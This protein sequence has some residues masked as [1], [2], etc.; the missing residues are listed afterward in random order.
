[1]CDRFIDHMETG[2]RSG[3]LVNDLQCIQNLR[4]FMKPIMVVTRIVGTRSGYGHIVEIFVV[5]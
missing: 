4:V 2:G 5:V 1:M 3:H